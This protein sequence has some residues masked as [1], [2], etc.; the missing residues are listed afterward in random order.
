MGEEKKRRRVSSA[1][2]K[3]DVATAGRGIATFVDCVAE[4]D[5]GDETPG[6]GGME[7][8]AGVR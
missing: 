4:T 3:S 5:L 1:L 7:G 6:Q 8:M 2:N